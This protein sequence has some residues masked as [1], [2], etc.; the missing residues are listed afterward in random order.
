MKRILSMIL[1]LCLLCSAVPVALSVSAEEGAV[2]PFDLVAPTRLAAAAFATGDTIQIAYAKDEAMSRWLASREDWD[3]CHAELVKIGY[4]D[5]AIG[6]QVDWSLDSPDD[7]HWSEVWDTFGYD[8]DNHYVLGDWAYADYNCTLYPQLIQTGW[9]F[10]YK[11]DPT[12]P[13]SGRWNGGEYSTGWKDVLTKDQYEVRED[14]EGEHYAFIDWTKHTLYV[15][16]RWYMNLWPL[17]GERFTLFSDWSETAVA[18]KEAPAWVPLTEK[19]LKAPQISD[20]RKTDFEDHDAPVYAFTL[21]V[22]EELKKQQIALEANSGYLYVECEVWLEG[23]NEWRQVYLDDRDVRGGEMRAQ[24]S[25]ALDEGETFDVGKYVKL[26]CRYYCSQYE[27]AGGEWL[28]EFYS[29]YSN[30]ITY[31]AVIITGDWG[32]VDGDSRITTTDARLTLQYAAKKIGEDKLNVALADVDGDGK[33]NTTD[34]RLILQRAA[35]KIQKF[36]VEE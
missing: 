26:R 36:P 32:N 20:F 7:W 17:E 23:K 5:A 16:V 8:E 6:M 22:P 14:S 10:D 33:I 24:L 1:T 4:D 34:A 11:G 30:V 2:L 18:G 3:A 13:D 15:R 31:G 27:G 29:D 28:N 19:T 21:T 35:N 12:D 9:I 25:Y